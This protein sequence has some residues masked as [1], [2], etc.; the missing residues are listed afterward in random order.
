MSSRLKSSR[1]SMRQSYMRSVELRRRGRLSVCA[2]AIGVT[3]LTALTPNSIAAVS[4]SP[5]DRPTMSPKLSDEGDGVTASFKAHP[6][7]SAPKLKASRI[8]TSVTPYG[9]D[10][11]LSS[12]DDENMLKIRYDT[13]SGQPVPRFV[14]AKGQ[15][16]NCR[17]GP[18]F[19]HSIAFTFQRSGVPLLVIAESKDH[20]RKVRDADGDECWVY[21][22]TIKNTSHVL[23]LDT[24]TVFASRATGS[25]KRATL[26]PG[27]FA[28]LGKVKLD[29]EGRQWFFL[30]TN[31][32]RGWA[33][34]D[35]HLWGGNALAA[36][37]GN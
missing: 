30:S 19:N 16:T 36:Y 27:V 1:K 31:E 12:P 15:K 14:S 13:Y 32:A 4:P 24:T 26:A 10:K 11:T 7:I 22:T 28:R 5:A 6:R 34:G 21:R 25:M 18:S 9:R 2:G 23:V 35:D 20:W 37:A 17:R 8:A 3:A 29:E 33:L